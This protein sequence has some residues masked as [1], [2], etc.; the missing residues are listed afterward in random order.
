M[1]TV[2]TGGKVTT[3]NKPRDLNTE[4]DP[5]VKIKSHQVDAILVDASSEL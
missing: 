4:P 3:R 5:F 1:D 2:L